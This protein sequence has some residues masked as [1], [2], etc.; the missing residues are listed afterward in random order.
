LTPNVYEIDPPA[1][2]TDEDTIDE[3]VGVLRWDCCGLYDDEDGLLSKEGA[4]AP[5]PFSC[6]RLV[7]LGLKVDDP[8]PKAVGG[9]GIVELSPEPVPYFAYAPVGGNRLPPKLGFSLIC[10]LSQS[11]IC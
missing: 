8:A 11:I 10:L 9:F 7:K 3:E 2:D 4:R 1:R 5:P 6:S